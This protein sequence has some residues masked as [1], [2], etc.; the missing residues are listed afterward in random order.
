MPHCK[1]NRQKGFTLPEMLI[2]ILLS[3]IL[4]MI[5]LV[6]I[7]NYMQYLQLTE[8]D[9]AAKE[10]FMSAQ[11]RATLLNGGKRLE[12]YVI[13]RND[14][15]KLDNVDVNPNSDETTQITA[16]YIHYNDP[17]I[18]E[19]LP[20][21]SVE[22]SLWNGDFYI[23]YE[24]ISA[25]VI[26]VFFSDKALPIESGFAEF[27]EK[28][29]AAPQNLRMKSKPMIGYYGGESANSGNTVSLRTPVINIY[30]E[31]KLQVE[32][33]YWI[34]RSLYD[35]NES[36]NIN[37]LVKLNYQGKEIDLRK[38][39]ATDVKEDFGFTYITYTYLWTLD[40]L[41]DIH[42]KDLFSAY[43]NDII[44][45]KDFTIT[46][47]VDYTGEMNVNGATKT[48]KDNSLFAKGSDGNTAYIEC[49]RHLQNLDTEF[50]SVDEKIY[51]V[52]KRDI[53]GEDGYVFIPIDNEKLQD[54][55]GAGLSIHNLCIGVKNK[56]SIG[57]FGTFA[58][59][60]SV[61]KKLRNI[62]LVGTKVSNEN[63]TGIPMGALVGTGS[64]INLTNCQVYWENSSAQTTN[65]REILGDSSK[66]FNYQIVG[67][68]ATG[69]LAGKLKN[70]KL[71]YCSAS[72]LIESSVNAGGLVGEASDINIKNSYVA[73]YLRAPSSAGFIGSLTG[74]AQIL[75]SYAVGFI[76]SGVESASI[77]AGLCLGSGN[78]NISN[79]YSAMLFSVGDNLTNYPLCKNGTYQNTY[80]LES[81]LFNFVNGT[82]HLAKSYDELT[83]STKWDSFFGQ[84]TF[85]AKSA[86]ETYP[87]NLQTTLSLTTFIYPGLA[88]LEHW[89]DWGAQF[90]NGSLVYYEKYDDNTYGF[91][92]G[93]MNNL[94]SKPIIDDGYAVA[95]RSTESISGIG[96]NLDITY[97]AG[98]QEQTERFGYGNGHTGSIYEITNLTD[99]TGQNNNYYLLPLPNKVVNTDY[100]AR[101]FYQKI[102]VFDVSERTERS[103]YYNPH[104]A[105][106]ILPFDEKVDINKLADQLRVEIRSPRHLYMLSRFP[107]YYA[108][109][110]Q[111]RFLQQQNL[112]YNIYIGY[113][114]FTGDWEQSPIGI[115]ATSPFRGSYYG[116][117][118]TITGVR[119]AVTDTWGNN[120]QYVGLFGYSTSV[121]RDIV[122]LMDDIS[123]FSVTQRG[124]NSPI[125]YVGGLVGYNGGTIYNC[126]VSGARFK[127]ECYM[128]STVYL[129]GLVG[130]N[131]GAIR[132]SSADVAYVTAEA[133]MSNAYVG[134]FV[135]RNTAGAIIEQCYVVG[136][137]FASRARHGEVY[138]CGFAAQNEATLNRS[139]A[140]VALLVDGGGKSYGFSPNASQKCVYLNDGNFT[141]RDKHYAAQY[142]DPAATSVT[143][144][145]LAGYESKAEVRA[146]GMSKGA[147]SFDFTGGYPY[148]SIVK[149]RTN[150]PIHYGQWPDRMNL[151]DMGVYYWEKIDDFYYLSVISV[152]ANKVGRTSTL[153]TVHGDGKVVSEYGYGYYHRKDSAA[154]TT[155]I[156]QGIY[157]NDSLFDPKIIPTNSETD[158]AL[159]NLMSGQYTFYSYNTWQA[160]NRKGLHLLVSNADTNSAEQPVGV[161]TLTQGSNQLTVNINPMF[162][163]SM[164]NKNESLPGTKKNPYQVRS[165]EQLQFINWNINTKNTKTVLIEEN[166]NMFPYLS[167]GRNGNIVQRDFY[168]EQTHDIRG[169]D[170]V[171]YTPIAEFYD[172]TGKNLGGLFGWFGGT[173][174]GNDYLIAD[175]NIVGQ[176]S[177][178]VGLF[179]SV[180]NGV[181]KN[182]VLHS[183]DGTAVV[184][185]NDSGDSRWYA[186]GGLVGIAA[187]KQGSSLI[188]CTVTGYTIK[189]VHKSTK[190]GGWGGTG[191]GGLVGVSNMNLEG[192]TA[193]VTIKLD[194]ADNDNVRVGGLV[195]SCQG[196]ISSCYTGGSII[197]APTS[198]TPIKRGIYIGSIVGGIYMKPLGVG[199][200]SNIQVGRSGQDLQNTLQNCY[201]YVIL[202][203][204]SENKYIKGLYAVGG[205]GELNI[206]ATHDNPEHKNFDHGWTN[207]SNN[208]YLG[209]VV[210]QNNNNTIT[211]N[212]NDLDSV[213]A[214]T[215]SQMEDSETQNGLLYKLNSN[216]GGFSTV[217]TVTAKG[218][219]ISG[220]YS[221]GSDGSLLGKNYPFPTILTQK[222]SVVE[223]GRANVHY[224]DWPLAGIRRE[225]GALPVQFDIFAEPLWSESLT[226]SNVLP[227]GKWSVSSEKE[228]VAKGVLL[229]D[230]EEHKRIL[231]ITSQSEGNT[232]LTVSYEINNKIYTLP[233]EVNVTAHLRLV[234][235]ANSPIQIFTDKFAPTDKVSDLPTANIPLELQDKKGNKISKD[236]DIELSN[237]KVEFD[238][239]FFVDANVNQQD[240]NLSL[241]ATSS[242]NVG[243]TQMTVE[244]DFT[245]L[246]RN[247]HTT[248]V[249]ILVV[250]NPKVTISPLKVTFKKGDKDKRI[251]EYT[252]ENGF[253]LSVDGKEKEV[254]NI[255]ITAFEQA[256]AEFRDIIWVE[257]SKNSDGSDKIG[258]L[259]TTIYPPKIYPTNA[260]FKIQFKFDCDGATYTQW[261]NLQVQITETS[262]EVNP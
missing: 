145:Q 75:G 18:Q 70:A 250:E 212:K 120:Y 242:T 103:Y 207:Y 81:D 153:P 192:C 96:A 50:S 172:P 217:T 2:V 128:Y 225:Y 168:W 58:G 89:G 20:K 175:V 3:V 149:S 135:G 26:D 102:T 224:G 55:D 243:S 82:E 73:T 187:S 178:C 24:P 210:L 61:P 261:Q 223:N 159:S 4:L 94:V 177:S 105:N 83:D 254:K 191:L 245:Y 262:K 203:K 32:V 196:R 180:F 78:A 85:T 41:D 25:S 142:D 198:T 51:A 150:N 239:N 255:S 37:L 248:S 118:H 66:G 31:N 63:R 100:A 163:D 129:G 183:T 101:D 240:N 166:G 65:L 176:K 117:N 86:T 251:Y 67:F 241:N 148:P 256:P 151:G 42:F 193:V 10:I 154:P 112:D 72:T 157:W 205:S 33:K 39:M 221:F 91:N 113:D 17:N 244:Y 59:T 80:Y 259:S 1:K 231:Q 48:A 52:Q 99:T 69:G 109:A 15:N 93:G 124:N 56:N 195:G 134:G 54:Y 115:D 200:S 35:I 257:W 232:I 171:N 108:S 11:N 12:K 5:S 204:H 123:S 253:K 152:D 74:N 44:Y 246:G 155:L 247:Y 185:G 206:D 164:S 160:E 92:G 186:I 219:N 76:D 136:S 170:G 38:D 213:T 190:K 202:P 130:L 131:K 161:L 36:H 143:W 174:D 23:V 114:L 197:V 140:A 71:E 233:I 249:L 49:L 29:R 158:N 64:Y 57:L 22:P 98:G 238:P 229:P 47:K 45:G 167:F 43:G 9:N 211:L 77:A 252:G 84:N 132:E 95:Y 97:W 188:N 46:A 201:S 216:G 230:G 87:Y 137:L 90:Q 6:G 8:L 156:N 68:G 110:H 127:A 226:L 234:A 173:Y 121:L 60:E 227:G 21:Q 111:Y 237:F 260:W 125:L 27:Y 258:A 138:V 53:I 126:A 16:Y 62:R 14:I 104:F 236:L 79:S 181:L 139:Y 13:Q 165:I 88:N 141:Y 182:I 34:P 209:T 144:K 106:T 189:D 214:L 194:S 220:R 215:Y 218:E 228:S 107:V 28:W 184:E 147:E 133:N 162:A 116:N 208:Y 19:L 179:G 222:S 199:G 7:I 235:T 122:Y 40:S 169:K 119:M 146:L 30:N